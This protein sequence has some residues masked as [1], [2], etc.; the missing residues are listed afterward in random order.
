[1]YL[2]Y[3]LPV[4]F[5]LTQSIAVG[6]ERFTPF[7]LPIAASLLTLQ[8]NSTAFFAWIDDIVGF[9]ESGNINYS[10]EHVEAIPIDCYVTQAKLT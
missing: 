2:I 3:R 6:E 9:R 8:A 7:F 10:V 4:P 1:M 5:L